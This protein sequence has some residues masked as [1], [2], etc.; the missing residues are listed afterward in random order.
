MSQPVFPPGIPAR[1]TFTP[2]PNQGS[3]AS[4]PPSLEQIVRIAYEQGH[5]DV[6]L[7]IGESPRFRARGEITRS[8]WPP[9]EPSEFQDWLGELLTPQQIDLFRQS[10]EFDGAHAFPFVRVR[11]NL[12]D[13]LKGAAMVLRLIPQKILSLDDL[14]L[15]PVLQELCAYP[16]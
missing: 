11:I 1:P 13:A 8:D 6:H 12:F 15:P 14:N 4:L 10:K 3:S 9:T 2:P 16:K 7:G 5:S